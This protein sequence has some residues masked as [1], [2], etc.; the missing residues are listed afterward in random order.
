MR[1]VFTT[2]VVKEQSAEAE[3]VKHECGRNWEEIN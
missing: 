3:R 2:N 1:K